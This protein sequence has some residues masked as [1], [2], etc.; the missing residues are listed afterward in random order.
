M[1]ARGNEGILTNLLN[2]HKAHVEWAMSNN[3][4]SKSERERA[5]EE[6][7]ERERE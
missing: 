6:K 7:I 1:S 4:I 5:K 2:K 3:D